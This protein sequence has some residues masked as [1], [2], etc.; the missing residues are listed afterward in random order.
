VEAVEEIGTNALITVGDVRLEPC[1]CSL[2]PDADVAAVA[3]RMLADDSGFVPICAGGKLVG[4]VYEEDLLR[5]VAGGQMPPNIGPLISSQIPTCSPKSALVDA[6]RL[7]LS[8]WVRKLP[9]VGDAGELVGVL[10]LSEAAAVAFLDPPIADLLERF[11]LSPSL[12]AR[13]MR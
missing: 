3:Q 8:C 4:V 2:A 9:V 1:A 10:T 13:R 11:S 12:F 5:A 7:M 6:V